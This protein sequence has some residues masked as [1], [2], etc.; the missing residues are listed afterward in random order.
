MAITINPEAF[1]EEEGIGLVRGTV[2]QGLDALVRAGVPSKWLIEGL[3]AAVRELRLD[4]AAND[5][6][7][8]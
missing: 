8:G 6:A 3:Q 1:S 2:R 5:V 7:A 4:H